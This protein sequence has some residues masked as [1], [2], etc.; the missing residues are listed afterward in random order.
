MSR[1]LYRLG[2]GS[3]R[4]RR[5]VLLGWLFGVIALF[6][7]GK[8]AGGEF[9]DKFNVPGVESQKAIDLLQNTFPAQAGGSAQVVFHATNG[10]LTDSTAS[11]VVADTISRIGQLEHVTAA[12]DPLTTG[13]VSPDGTIA[14]AN[15]RYDASSINL[16]KD[17]FSKLQTAVQPAVD[18]GVQVEFGGEIPMSANQA[19]ASASEGIGILAAMVILLFAFGSVIAMGLPI[20]T[21]VFGLGA[22]LATIT[23]LSAFIDMP[24]T[25]EALATMIGLGVG[26]DYAL[27]IITR[28]R[29]GLHRGLTVEDAAGRAIATAGQAVLIAGGT[30]V[31]AICGLAVAGVPLVTFMGI[32]AAIVVAVMVA[33]SL[34]MLPAFIGFAGHNI[35]RFGIPGTRRKVEAGAKDANGSYHG[36]ARWSHHVS[37]HPVRY[38]IGSFAAVLALASPMLDMRLGQTDASQNPTS[39]TLRRSY[40]LLATGFGPGF[41]GPL[42]LAVD[43]G[44]GDSKATLAA[45]TTAV[46]ADPGVA[47]VAPASLNPNG[48]SAVIQVSPTSA[49]QDAATGQLVNR[50][51]HNVL[52]ATV[53]NTDSHVYVGGQTATFIDLS[54]RISSRLPLF[55]GVVIG[56]SFLLLMVVFRSILVPLK[57]ALMN[58]LSIGAAYGVIVAV[59]Q[60]GWGA[61]LFGVH[62]SLPIISFIP[63]FMFAILFGL[64]MDY[65]VFLLSR[66]REEYLISGD[67]TESVVVGITTTARVI[68]SAAL[69]M[70]SVFLSF[71]FGG[72]PTIKMMGLGLATAVFV[73]ATIIRMIL[74]PAT[75][76][77]LGDANWWMPKWLD[78]L[79]PNLD[80]EGE[81]KLPPE[82]LE[83]AAGID[84][85]G[86]ATD[87]DKIA[88]P[89]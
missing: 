5:L 6:G 46:K 10:Q 40:D 87:D 84:P 54:N 31:I 19:S 55:I 8:A 66:I 35:D 60:K 3:V 63:M 78:R 45:I 16:P 29:A 49:P 57:A 4:H 28:H 72:E 51:R 38:L 86:L 36:W 62:E 89:V 47:A 41:N 71:V 59:F 24:S 39:S 15:V 67:N 32:G 18:A 48:T 53:V 75:M 1:F 83:A 44:T 12:P 69:I 14:L 23:F 50:L 2:R 42:V 65:E 68:T 17:T 80:I 76:R 73:D 81:S 7:I 30:V 88:V 22:G 11:T 74:V 27:F 33:A 37:R 61:S 26:I 85:A 82:E 25:S 34:T 13:T 64:S 56:L 20:G 77:L 21:A 58:V 9:H 43:L 70:I 79:L 52:P